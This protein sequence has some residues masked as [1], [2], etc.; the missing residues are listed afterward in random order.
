[1]ADLTT[2]NKSLDAVAELLAYFHSLDLGEL[3]Q[4]TIVVFASDHGGFIGIDK[5]S[6]Q[7]IPV[8]NNSPLRSGK[9]SCY[10]GGG[11]RAIDC[12][13]ARRDAEKCRMRPAGCRDGSVSDFAGCGWCDPVQRC[14]H[15]IP[16][17]NPIVHRRSSEFFVKGLLFNP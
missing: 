14:Q 16:T 4:N 11:P 9:G 12:S 17:K 8:T 1:M 6:G 7:T 10:E 2:N 15:L 5:Q 13:L 3:D